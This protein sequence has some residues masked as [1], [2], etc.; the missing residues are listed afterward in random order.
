MRR[1]PSLRPATSLL[2]A[3][4]CLW[5]AYARADSEPYAPPSPA[6]PSAGG[7]GH[8]YA[9]ARRGRGH[10]DE[11]NLLAP[12]PGYAV[13]HLHSTFHPSARVEVFACIDNLFNHKYA[14]WGILSDPTG[15]GAPGI[16]PGGVTNGP[17]VD[18]R[19]LS[20]A[21]PLEAF[22]GARLTL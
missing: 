20:P 5:G 19:F 14:T 8:G 17:G 13:V 11:A 4:A 3:A 21:A 16:P 6:Q 7:R 9:A 22:L 1:K 18:N 12:I 2:A 10:R 15:I